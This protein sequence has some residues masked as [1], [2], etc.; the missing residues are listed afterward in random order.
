MKNNFH[1]L[2]DHEVI[3]IDQSHQINVFNPTCTSNEFLNAIKRALILLDRSSNSFHWSESKQEWFEEDGV[4]GEV[5]Q[6]GE[7]DWQ[8][9]RLKLALVF[10]PDEPEEKLEE[11]ENQGIELKE[12]PLLEASLEP[13]ETSA[14]P[15]DELRK[16]ADETDS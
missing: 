12:V 15:L 1:I 14:E 2:D 13:I 16:L 5:L 3:S 11:D 7:K 8:S 6:F 4:E 10:Y 9:G